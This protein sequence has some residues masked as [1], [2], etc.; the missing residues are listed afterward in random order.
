[1][2]KLFFYNFFGKH[3]LL[4]NSN[5]LNYDFS[6]SNLIHYVK[7]VMLNVNS[8]E[9]D[10]HVT[11]YNYSHNFTPSNLA[12]QLWK[13]VFGPSYNIIDLLKIA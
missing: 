3:K 11:P 1:M 7:F 10:Y 4:T 6:I 9:I 2:F 12:T 5:M 13:S 8:N